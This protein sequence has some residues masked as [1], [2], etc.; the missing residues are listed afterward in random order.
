MARRSEAD[1]EFLKMLAGYGLAT[2]EIL[3]RM[4]DHL[5]VL[6]TYVWQD[7]DLEPQFPELR[8]FLG[9]W[10]RKLDGPLYQVRV[11]HEHLIK[12]CEFKVVGHQLVL[13]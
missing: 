2:A 11:A 4:P 6:Q 13:H 5:H 9:F 10:H 12:P 7:Y 3:Y 1:P 8:K